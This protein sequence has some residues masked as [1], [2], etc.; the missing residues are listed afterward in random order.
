M[1]PSAKPVRSSS[2]PRTQGTPQKRAGTAFTVEAGGPALSLPKLRRLLVA[3][4]GFP[5]QH[6][7]SVWQFLL[8]LP[9]SR[10]AWDSLKSCG[11]HP[12]VSMLSEQYAAASLPSRTLACLLSSVQSSRI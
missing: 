2:A 4:G 12:C 10:Q 11:E 7:I 5:T 9:N 6:R 8:Q 3:T 1:Q